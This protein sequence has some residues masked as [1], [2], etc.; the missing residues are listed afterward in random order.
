MFIL[1]GIAIALLRYEQ[2]RE[3]PDLSGKEVIMEGSLSSLPSETEKGIL[4]QILNVQSAFDRNTHRK[5]DELNNKDV[6]IL[7]DK[8]FLPGIECRILAKILSNK[9]G[10]NPGSLI[11]KD[12]YAIMLELNHKG[13]EKS[14]LRSIIQRLR[15]RLNK[16]IMAN[17]EKDS[18]AFISAITTGHR[19]Y[20]NEDLRNAF[21]KTGLA[22]VLSI[23]GTHFGLFSVFLFG[24]FR[25]M[26]NILPYRLLQ[27]ITI[28]FTPSQAAALF[29]LP[30]MLSYLCLSGGNIPAIRSFIMIS[31][32]LI[33]L[34][35][36][37]KGSWLNFLLF[38]AFVLSIRD[39]KV[40]FD[41]SF[42][43]SFIAVLFIGFTIKGREYLIEKEKDSHDKK[44]SKLTQRI[45]IYFKKAFL[46]ALSASIGT[47]PLVAY[48]FH[49]LSIISPLSNLLIT[50]FIGFILIP[51]SILS[52]FLFLTTG[53]YFFTP[54]VSTLSDI[55]IYLVKFISSIPCADIKI[56]AF[57]TI[58]ILLFYAGFIFYLFF[59]EKRYALI[60]P[61]IPV[62]IYISFLIF[63][64]KGLSVTYLD[65]GQGDSSV[66]ELPDGK[67]I[68]I[69]TGRNGRETASFLKYKGKDKIDALILSHIHSDHTG[70]L[71]YILNNF[72]VEELWDNGNLIYP[73]YLFSQTKHK[74]IERGDMIEANGYSIYILHP[75]P[76]FYTMYGDDHVEAN[77]SS[78]VLKIIGRN[79]S[80]LF[81]G[82]IEKEAE[83]DIL[84]LGT[85]LR[86]DVIKIPH[87]GSKTSAY[88]PFIKAVSPK[89]AVISV[90]TNNPFG[91]PHEDMIR[92]LDGVKVIRTDIEGAIK[93]IESE[94]GLIIKTYKD[95]QFQHATSLTEE[96]RNLKRLF[97]TW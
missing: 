95:F 67:I 22:H 7:S 40:I 6:V 97:E 29:C 2:I 12:I 57:P 39:P 63:E 10:Q 20:V 45:L 5:I 68:V 27:R 30:F 61:F 76:D 87:Q 78:L 33:G 11:S 55:C 32:F 43:L 19:S 62:L 17:L 60:I 14:S 26:I 58:I 59:K 13:M 88:E 21:N 94:K 81:T 42:Q 93:I 52:A 96:I 8:E 49:Y 91:H 75:Y 44:P 54:I 48:H 69:D 37:R 86:S 66:I 72:N 77:N 79:S 35:L 56:P 24:I 70:G 65:V 64:K 90:A 3:L 80:F 25:L 46:I 47:A 71:N 34:L 36:G 85:L 1:F 92:L 41:L 89:F 31:L 23:S 18:S 51:L 53:H 15:Y 28:F 50:P 84:H 83:E 9:T 16:Y 38:S 4:K 73:E 82:D 74:K